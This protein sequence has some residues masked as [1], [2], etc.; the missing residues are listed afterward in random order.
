MSMRRIFTS[1][2]LIFALGSLVYTFILSSD[3]SGVIPSPTRPTENT[4]IAVQGVDP[5]FAVYFFYNDIYCSTCEKL[6]N[7]ALN[8]VQENYADELTSGIM[9][10]RTLDMRT[11]ENKHFVEDF[12]LYSKSIVLLEFNDTAIARYKNLEDI[13]ELVGDQEDYESY[14]S[15]SLESF[16]NEPPEAS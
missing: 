15:N 8:A 3:D 11:P 10:W 4:Q 12:G 9:Q 13:W 7:Y 5:V 6:E 16:M 14:I 2:I 1:L